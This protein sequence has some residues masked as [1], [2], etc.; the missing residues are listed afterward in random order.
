MKKTCLE[1]QR[2]QVNKDKKE[3]KNYMGKKSGLRS[4]KIQ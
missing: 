1:L 4:R 2:G 3:V